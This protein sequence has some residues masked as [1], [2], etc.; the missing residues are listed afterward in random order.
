MKMRENPLSSGDCRKRAE[1]H[2]DKDKC[3][4]KYVELYEELL[5]RQITSGGTKLGIDQKILTETAILSVNDTRNELLKDFDS[6]FV[7]GEDLYP[8]FE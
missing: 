3:F 5:N 1:E 4:E 7:C 8:E 6:P 2:F